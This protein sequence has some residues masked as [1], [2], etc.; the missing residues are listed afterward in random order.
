MYPSGNSI[1]VSSSQGLQDTKPKDLGNDLKKWGW[2]KKGSSLNN[3]QPSNPASSTGVNYSNQM[4]PTNSSSSIRHS[5][6][7]NLPVWII[8]F[9]HIKLDYQWKLIGPFF[10]FFFQVFWLFWIKWYRKS[11]QFYNHFFS[12]EDERIFFFFSFENKAILFCML[13]I[14]RQETYLYSNKNLFC[15][16][17]MYLHI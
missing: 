10:Y 3:L 13:Q 12:F 9:W 16:P 14:S 8:T 4:Y 5:W 11:F 1:S 7:Y 6:F 15:M 2:L 17:L